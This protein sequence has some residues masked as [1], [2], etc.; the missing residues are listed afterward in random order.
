MKNLYVESPENQGFF[1]TWERPWQYC[2]MDELK[3]KKK[4]LLTLV[5]I[6]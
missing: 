1:G 2:L 3:M 4:I 5:V 6:Q